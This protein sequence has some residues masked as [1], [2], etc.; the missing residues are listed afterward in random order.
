ML[1]MLFLD[2]VV[3]TNSFVE[4]GHFGAIEFGDVD[5]VLVD[6]QLICQ[7]VAPLVFTIEIDF[8]RRHPRG[9]R[10]AQSAAVLHGYHVSHQRFVTVVVQ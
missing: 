2:F 1:L 8:D 10:H 7:L 6:F 4:G 5:F 3:F 9:V